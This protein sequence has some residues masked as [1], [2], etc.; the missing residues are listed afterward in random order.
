MYDELP[1]FL[2]GNSEAAGKHLQKAVSLDA[3]YAP[4]R[5]DLGK[6]HMKHGRFQEASE[7]FIKILSTPPLK[8]RWIWERIHK[9]QAQILLRQIRVSQSP[10]PLG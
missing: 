10:D 6:W 8:K 7:E 2:G 5:L 4:G 1:W 9:P 3:R